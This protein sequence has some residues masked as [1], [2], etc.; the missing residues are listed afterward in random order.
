MIVRKTVVS[1]ENGFYPSNRKKLIKIIEDSFLSSIGP[2]RLP[3]KY[4]PTNKKIFGLIVPHAGLM[5]SGHEAA[6]SYLK[7]YETKLP[8]TIIL[9]GPNHRGLGETISIY[10][11]ESWDTP[12][13]NIEID[14]K[15]TDEILSY[16]LFSEDNSSHMFEHSLEVQL[17]FIKYIYEKA[18][19]NPKIVAISLINQDLETCKKIGE[20]LN[21]IIKDREDVILIASSDFSHYVPINFA[22][23]YDILAIDEILN[24]NYRE[25]Y[26]KIDEYSLSICGVGPITA[27]TRYS[28]L[29]GSTGGILLKYGTSGDVIPHKEVVGYGAVV[30]L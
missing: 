20:C 3:E 27:V 16:P 18:N 21:S 23:K 24:F 15:L 25:F 30:F 1:G 17:P 11:G 5:F 13:G 7:L 28:Q 4:I 12:L 8:K 9:I 10:K 6:H 29:S 22:K 14:K 26:K 2:G 19:L